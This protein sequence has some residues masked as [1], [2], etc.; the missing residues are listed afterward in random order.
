M[1]RPTI[2]RY[3]SDHPYCY[4]VVFSQRGPRGGKRPPLLDVNVWAW[5]QEKAIKIAKEYLTDRL[6][7]EVVK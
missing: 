7:V 6:A 1:W 4:R 3:D 5:S 2:G